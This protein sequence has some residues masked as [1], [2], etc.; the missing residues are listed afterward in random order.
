MHAFPVIYGPTASGKSDL[1]VRVARL[2]IGRGLHAEVLAAD[3]FQIYRGM[4]IGTAKPTP[5]E[6]GGI[7]HRLIDLADPHAATPFTVEDWLVHAE[8]A[9]AEVRARG[10][11]PVVVG[12]TSLYVQSLLRGLFQGPLA[13][14]AL[15]AELHA[16]DPA[17]LRAELGRVDPAAADR[18]HPGDLR[19]TVR[20]IE[21]FRLTGRPISEHQQQWEGQPPRPDA[22]LV[23]LHWEKEAINRRINARVKAMMAAGLLDEL[24]TLRAAGPL[25]PQAREALGYK[26]LAYHLEKGIPLL[27]AV[28]QIKV[29]TRRFAKNQRTW[30]RRLGQVPGRLLLEPARDD[31]DF[32]A[33]TIVTTTLADGSQAGGSGP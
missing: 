7:V 1:A 17:A 23:I 30:L 31:L 28:E 33:Q 8:A 29:E 32:L 2:L 18:I 11:V 25:G 6:R 14:A 4:D 3:A 19:R 9:I 20:A 13:D 15:R 26:Q 22:R 5:P 21:V 24:R 27:E 10:G 16:A 12:G